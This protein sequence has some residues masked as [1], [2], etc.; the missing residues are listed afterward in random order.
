MAY[1][2]LDHVSKAYGSTSVLEDVSLRVEQGDLYGILGLSGAGKSTLLRL[3][4]GLERPTSGTIYWKGEAIASPTLSVKKETRRKIA[5]IFQ[6]FGLLEQ[7]NALQNVHLAYEMG[8]EKD[9]DDEKSASLL[10]KVGLGEK[11]HAYPSE[12]SGGQKQRVAIARALALSPEILLCDEVTSALDGETSLEILSLLQHLHDE[13]GLTLIVI[14]HQL[15][16]L[17]NLCNK[18]ALL[19]HAKIVEEGPLSDVFLAP[20]SE[21]AK[22]LLYAGKIHTSLEEDHYIRL[23]FNGN[24]DTPL[25]S[26]IVQECG[27]VVSISFADTKVIAGKVYGQL[28]IHTPAKEKEK[29]KLKK[30]LSFQHVSFQEVNAHELV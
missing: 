26:N 23:T 30:Y 1:L 7:R 28:L 11:L 20:Q 13:L 22:N 18:V 9:E 5:M 16:V 14:S 21:I 24:V 25:V 27:I 12:L 15:S 17:E 4:N 8:G 29:E 2:L 10:R 19:D 3:I 6:L